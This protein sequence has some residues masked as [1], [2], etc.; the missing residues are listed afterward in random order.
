MGRSLA[1]QLEDD[2]AGVVARREQVERRV[3]RDHPE[4]VMLTAE[5]VQ[6]VPL[7]HVPHPN[8][9]H[10]FRNRKHRYKMLVCLYKQFFSEFDL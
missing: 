4:A 6:A 7:A 3:A 8:T 9:K 2:H 5:G 10:E 1:L